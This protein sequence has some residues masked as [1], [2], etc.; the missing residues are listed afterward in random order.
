MVLRDRVWTGRR[1]AYPATYDAD[2]GQLPNLERYPNL[3]FLVHQG[4]RLESTVITM[5]VTAFLSS[6]ID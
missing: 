5:Y 4:T 3:D 2:Q 6:H 1:A